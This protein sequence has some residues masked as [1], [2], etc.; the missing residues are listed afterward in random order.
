MVI[1]AQRPEHRVVSPGIRVRF[2]SVT[3]AELCIGSDRCWPAARRA[4]DGFAAVCS[5]NGIGNNIGCWM[6]G[7][8]ERRLQVSVVEGRSRFDSC[9]DHQR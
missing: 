2:P 7:W 6:L 3:L 4:S 1:V 8:H 5:V 9:P